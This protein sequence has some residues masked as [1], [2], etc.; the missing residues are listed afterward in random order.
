[1]VITQQ[2]KDISLMSY[3]FLRN[4]HALLN[5]NLFT[6]HRRILFYIFLSSR[7]QVDFTETMWDYMYTFLLRSSRIKLT[8]N[9]NACGDSQK[10]DAFVTGDDSRQSCPSHA[11]G[12]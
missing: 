4:D 5:L 3:D 11:F 10:Y 9:I 7:L 12:L 6:C 8:S 1:M 2:D